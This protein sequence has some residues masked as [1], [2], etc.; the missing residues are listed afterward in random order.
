MNNNEI[1]LWS[2]YEST[3]YWVTET[4]RPFCIKIDQNSY[5]LEELLKKHKELNW[6]YIT[7]YNPQSKKLNKPQ[8]INRHRN[9]VAYC[10]ERDYVFYAG[11]G[12]DTK[13]EW[14]PEIS[15]LII[16]IDMVTAKKLGKHFEQKAIL[17]GS[18]NQLPHLVPC[19]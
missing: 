11:E 6:T 16:G 1:K 9:L 4:E 13:K 5:E 15:L 17:C 14:D 2:A 12:T 18:L 8:N 7:A 10:T 19:H 3:D